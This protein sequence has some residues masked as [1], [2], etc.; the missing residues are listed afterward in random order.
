MKISFI[1]KSLLLMAFLVLV[2]L[3]VS[4]DNADEEGFVANRTEL[5]QAWQLIGYGSGTS[6]YMIDDGFRKEDE[7]YGFRFFLYFRNDGTFE[8]RDAVNTFFGTYTCKKGKIKIN[9][10]V[11]TLV[12]Y[13]KGYEESREFLSRFQNSTSYGIKD[14]NKLR[15]YSSR[16]EY[17]YFEAMEKP[18]YIEQ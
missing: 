18:W 10:I 14:G 12:G 2:G 4:C 17:L 11:S 9:D 13:S 15:L 7:I 1:S 16:D 6:F 5:N 3:S 8:G